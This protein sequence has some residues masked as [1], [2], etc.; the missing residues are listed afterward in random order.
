MV[1]E[2]DTVLEDSE[3]LDR[4]TLRIVAEYLELG[5]THTIGKIPMIRAIQDKLAPKE[6][7][8]IL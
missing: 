2:R 1:L 3:D 7:V 5:L 4:P 8:I 6:E